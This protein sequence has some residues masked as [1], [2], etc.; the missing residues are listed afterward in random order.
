MQG[1]AIG[2]DVN[3]PEQRAWEALVNPMGNEAVPSIGDL[4]FNAPA[5]EA[6]SERDMLGQMAQHQSLSAQRIAEVRDQR[7]RAAARALAR[8]QGKGMSKGKKG[9]TD[10]ESVDSGSNHPQQYG[11]NRRIGVY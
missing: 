11:Q 5:Y 10:Y 6:T 9:A 3:R 8:E 7:R 2:Q 1:R 4:V